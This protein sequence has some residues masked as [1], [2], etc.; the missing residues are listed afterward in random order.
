MR[1]KLKKFKKF[2]DNNLMDLNMIEQSL[3]SWIAHAKRYKSHKTIQSMIAL[4]ND[5]FINPFM[6]TVNQQKCSDNKEK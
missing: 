6:G 4:Y 2:Y 5:L 3:Q 1:R